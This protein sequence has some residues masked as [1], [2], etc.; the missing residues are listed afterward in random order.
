MGQHAR[1]QPAENLPDPADP[2]STRGSI[3][4]VTRLSP[5]KTPP[6]T[7]RASARVIKAFLFMSNLPQADLLRPRPHAKPEEAAIGE[8]DADER[9]REH[10]LRSNGSLGSAWNLVFSCCGILAISARELLEGAGL[11]NDRKPKLIICRQ[12]IGAC[13]ERARGR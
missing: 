4:A 11:D 5:K 7:P 2:V 8:H 1:R 10:N 12:A 6:T 13:Q 3:V 9:Q